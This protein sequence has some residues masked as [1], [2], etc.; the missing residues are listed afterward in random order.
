M[1]VRKNKYIGPEKIIHK[2]SNKFIRFIK[3]ICNYN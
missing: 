2:A 3:E 1:N